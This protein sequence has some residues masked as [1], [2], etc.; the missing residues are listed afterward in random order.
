MKLLNFGFVVA[1][2][3]FDVA[4]DE[5]SVNQ[6]ENAEIAEIPH[7]SGISSLLIISSYTFIL[8]REYGPRLG[9]SPRTTRLG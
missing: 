3:G 1:A 9:R 8:S 7:H 2:S 5:E 4:Y 6:M